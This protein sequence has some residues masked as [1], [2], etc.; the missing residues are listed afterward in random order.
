MILELGIFL[1]I[2]PSR[3]NNSSHEKISDVNSDWVKYWALRITE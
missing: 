3:W 1:R 2:L